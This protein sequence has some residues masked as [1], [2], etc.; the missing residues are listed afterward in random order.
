MKKILNSEKLRNDLHNSPNILKKRSWLEEVLREFDRI[1][2]E[3]I[4][5][6]PI[7]IP[8]FNHPLFVV[9]IITWNYQAFVRIISRNFFTYNLKLK[10]GFSTGGETNSLNGICEVLLQN[11]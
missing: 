8:Y 5:I 4:E 11:D 7:F 1:E 2:C 6:S 9:R 10:G 3:D